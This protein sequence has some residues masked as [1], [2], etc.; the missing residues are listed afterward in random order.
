VRLG[1][2]VVL[3]AV[4][5]LPVG[6]GRERCDGQVAESE[7]RAIAS[8][9]Y[10]DTISFAHIVR[11][12]RN[13]GISLH[14]DSGGSLGWT[15][16]VQESDADAAQRIISQ[17]AGLRPYITVHG[18]EEAEMSHGEQIVDRKWT[19][20]EEIMQ[21][22]QQAL[23]EHGADSEVGKI[24]REMLA[25]YPRRDLPELGNSPVGE[26]EEGA[27]PWFEEIP[28]K[29]FVVE[30]VQWAYRPF[31][32]KSRQPTTAIEAA[33]TIEVQGTR[34]TEHVALLPDE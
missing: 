28:E 9:V 17:D 27:K 16:Y 14:P 12:L 15:V 31:V 25:R 2:A 34:S 11:V 10:W 13:A 19:H 22:L 5:G 33:V 20:S 8:G 21:T 26:K 7:P 24:V 32:T 29:E 23:R 4:I 6:C 3:A 30:R 18:A 1:A